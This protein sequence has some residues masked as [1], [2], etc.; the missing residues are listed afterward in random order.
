MCKEG[1]ADNELLCQKFSNEVS[2]L[3]YK[4][5]VKVQDE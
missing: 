1:N 4:E 2:F 5:S 3:D